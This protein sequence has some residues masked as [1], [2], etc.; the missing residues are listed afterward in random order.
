MGKCTFCGFPGRLNTAG[1]KRGQGKPGCSFRN[2]R[3]PLGNSGYHR[4]GGISTRPL[5]STVL[6][7]VYP[8]TDGG[9]GP[10]QSLHSGEGCPSSV[11]IPPSPVFLSLSVSVSPSLCLPFVSLSLS[12][13]LCNTAFSVHLGTWREGLLPRPEFI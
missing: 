12:P 1:M 6:H 11:L 2:T 3:I 5:L 8:R 9:A 13:S 4:T 7:S 10:S